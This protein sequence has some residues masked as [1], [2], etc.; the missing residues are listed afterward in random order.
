M[1]QGENQHSRAARSGY[2]GGRG[3]GRGK[4]EQRRAL[5]TGNQLEMPGEAGVRVWKKVGDTLGH[6]MEMVRV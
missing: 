6:L 3:G 1:F 4:G 2:G 5:R